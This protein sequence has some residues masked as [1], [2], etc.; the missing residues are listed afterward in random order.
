[1]DQYE[2]LSN[3]KKVT[4]IHGNMKKEQGKIRWIITAV[5]WTWEMLDRIFRDTFLGFFVDKP[6]ALWS[7]GLKS[8]VC[9]SFT[10][11][12][13]THTDTSLAAPEEAHEFVWMQQGLVLASCGVPESS[14][15]ALVPEM[16]PLICCAAGYWPGWGASG[17]PDPG[18][19]SHPGQWGGWRP[20]GER[21]DP[22]GQRR[23]M[24]GSDWWYFCSGSDGSGNAEKKIV[25]PT[26]ST[27]LYVRFLL[28]SFIKL[29]KRFNFIPAIIY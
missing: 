23:H 18:S 13:C 1:M 12:L 3:L 24:A 7:W 26:R 25:L 2:D 29:C 5:Q 22:G 11:Q 20:G 21:E 17:S 14:G 4:I 19:G 27:L 28:P 16:L 15:G 6:D 10:Q 9:P 8:S